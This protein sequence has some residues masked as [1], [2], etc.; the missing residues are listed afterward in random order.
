MTKTFTYDDVVRY[1][2]S[3]TTT[4]EN[5]KI[6]EALALSDDLM[7]FYLDSLEIRQQMNKI[8]LIPSDKVTSEIMHY[9]QARVSSRSVMFND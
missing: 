1:I 7:D 3:E 4:D 8:E 5:A 9:S 2:Y 6:I